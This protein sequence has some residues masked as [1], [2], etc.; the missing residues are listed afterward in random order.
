MSH[1]KLWNSNAFPLYFK[2]YKYSRGAPLI[3][4]ALTIRIAFDVF[5]IWRSKI[6]IRALRTETVLGRERG[7]FEYHTDEYLLTNC[8]SAVLDFNSKELVVN[9]QELWLTS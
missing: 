5:F 7:T 2:G 9:R 6:N 1:D 8:L 3:P 4:S